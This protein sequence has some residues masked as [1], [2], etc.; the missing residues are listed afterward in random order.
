MTDSVAVDEPVLLR[1]RRGGSKEDRTI[2]EP[3][4][5]TQMLKASREGGAGTSRAK[6]TMLA[7]ALA[8]YNANQ[9]DGRYG[10][11]VYDSGHLGR[12]NGA[13]N[14][15]L[16]SDR[17][18]RRKNGLHAPLRLHKLRGGL[19][20]TRSG[21][22]YQKVGETNRHLTT[23]DSIHGTFFVEIDGETVFLL[24]CR[25]AGGKN[26]T[27][28]DIAISTERGLDRLSRHLMKGR[29]LITKLPK[30]GLYLCET[31]P[32]GQVSH[33]TPS[34]E[35]FEK[36]ER[37]ET[38]PNFADLLAD[39]ADFFD[40]VA[41]HG[42]NNQPAMRKILLC[43]PP[44]S[45]KTSIALALG[46][47]MSADR[48]VVRCET[49]NAMFETSKKASE[50]NVPTIIIAEELDFLTTGEASGHLLNWL[51]GSTTPRNPAGTYVIATTNHPKRIDPRI[52]KRPGRI[53]KVLT[54]PALNETNSVP[55]VTS[56]LEGITLSTG[57][58][59]DRAGID[60]RMTTPAEIREIIIRA[61]RTMQDPDGGLTNADLL[62]TRIA[63]KRELAEASYSDDIYDAPEDREADFEST[64]SAFDD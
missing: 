25:L 36:T 45:G 39:C 37:F 54:I 56:F 32:Y 41:W 33:F 16:T 55:V 31:H 5:I 38:H 8:W 3:P 43:G 6:M 30:K 11:V 29:R 2:I 59:L 4:E 21:V 44:G 48:A 23:Y 10:V 49:S 14:K 18:E 46:K 26:T 63:M 9:T 61:A 51:D 52:L 57:F 34:K 40:N 28:V 24:S 7:Q 53:D 1:F 22:T 47:R 12:I 35:I 62:S 20:H 42:R 60:M 50:G 64:A 19:P 58:S 13:W 17:S 15:W 27:V